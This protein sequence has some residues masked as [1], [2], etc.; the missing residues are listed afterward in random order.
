MDDN[1]DEN[2]VDGANLSVDG[3]SSVPI[4]LE[5]G[6][7]PAGE[8]GRFLDVGPFDASV[9][10]TVDFAFMPGF[11]LALRKT[12]ALQ[13]D[14]PLVPGT[15]TV[16]FEIEIFNQGDV[17]ADSIEISDYIPSGLTLND[18]NWLMNGGNAVRTLSVANNDMPDPLAPGDSIAVQ[19]SFAV[20]AGVEGILTNYAEISRATD[21]NGNMVTDIDST[22]DG[23][24]NETAIINDEIND[25]GTFDEDDHDLACISV[26]L[27]LCEGHSITLGAE[28]GH[29]SY[30]WYKDGAELVGETTETLTITYDAGGTFIGEYNYVVDGGT[31]GGC[32]G[33]LC[34][35]I[36][37][38]EGSCPAICPPVRCIP[39]NVTKITN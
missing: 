16:T 15:S 21:E 13:S 36:Q 4:T 30:Q 7:E 37:V 22:P 3:I 29:I 11:D 18:A 27:E 25:D 5:S 32:N 34:C 1:Q 10:F 38:V 39:I 9:N 20:N 28:S 31:L 35:P 26:P 8:P 24:N 33:Q 23:V 12:L 2:G 19:I 14:D 6:M 17:A